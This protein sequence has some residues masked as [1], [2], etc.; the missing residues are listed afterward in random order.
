MQTRFHGLALGG[1]EDGGGSDSVSHFIGHLV[2]A[3]LDGVF[4]LSVLRPT[5]SFTAW[6]QPSTLLVGTRKNVG[7]PIGWL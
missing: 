5:N 2:L 6:F 1:R 4:I 7:P 3:M